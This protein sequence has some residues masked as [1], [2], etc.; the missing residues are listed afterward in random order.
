MD[1]YE[2]GG[3]DGSGFYLLAVFFTCFELLLFKKPSLE[4]A[5]SIQQRLKN[6]TSFR[7]V[8]KVVD[9]GA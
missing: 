6:D 4:T 9:K 3:I 7:N 5:F 2:I 8:P 1:M